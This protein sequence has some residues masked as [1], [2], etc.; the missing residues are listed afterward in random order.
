M[1]PI[2][3]RIR[4]H[5]GH[6]LSAKRVTIRT[7]RSSYFQAALVAGLVL[8]GAGITYWVMHD[9]EIDTIRQQ[10]QQLTQQNKA[11]EVKLVGAQ[12]ELQVELATNNNLAKELASVHDENLKIK[13]DLMFYKNMVEGKKRR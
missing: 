11:L 8:F 13:E 7:H 10:L 6:T 5:F 1:K 12:R 9:G 3:R 4:R 2:R